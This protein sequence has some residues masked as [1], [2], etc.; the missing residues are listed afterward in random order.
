MDTLQMCKGPFRFRNRVSKA[1][2][3]NSLDGLST[4]K[5]STLV[6]IRG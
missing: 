5:H 2:I 6:R 3:E 4:Q 1:Q